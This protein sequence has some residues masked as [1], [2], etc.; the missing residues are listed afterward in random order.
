MIAAAQITSP[1]NKLFKLWQSLLGAKGIEKHG[2]ALVSGRKIVPELAADASE[3][4][5]LLLRAGNPYPPAGEGIKS[6]RTAML[7]PALF[8][9]LDEFGTHAPL[10][11]V[12]APQIAAFDASV[13][14]RGLEV[15]LASQDPSNLGAILRSALAFGVSR[16]ILLQECAH[17]FL[18]KVTRAAAGANFAL[19]LARG[20]SIRALETGFAALDL[21][22]ADIEA[23]AFPANC[24]LVLGEEG[25]GIPEGFRGPRL[26]IP[27]ARAAE[28]LNVAVA[29]GIALAAYRR[30]HPL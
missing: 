12:P 17:P 29:A 8:D 16:A 24:R 23:F 1:D 21:E 2:L 25:A 9:A 15:A 20:P 18:P 6:V 11:V 22:G 3:A 4:A 13:G 30:Q 10:L 5:T 26:R 28:S 7:A 19:S 14:P 27:I